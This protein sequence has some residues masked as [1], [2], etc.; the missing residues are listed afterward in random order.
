MI[1]RADDNE[2]DES[3]VENVEQV[4]GFSIWQQIVV[5]HSSVW[6]PPTDVYKTDDRLVIL[7]EIAG[8]RDGDFEVVLHNHRLIISG[9]RQH[10]VGPENVA[11]HQ[12]EIQR[13][14]FRT[15]VHIPWRFQREHVTATY[16]DGLLRIE[17]PYLPSRPVH[18][19]NVNAQ[20]EA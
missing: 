19:I 2:Q 17:L 11:Y 6:C 9:V 18:I 3:S 20:E 4:S 5:R 12:L 16:R 8:L 7:V 1:T 10:L 15:E 14:A 13:G